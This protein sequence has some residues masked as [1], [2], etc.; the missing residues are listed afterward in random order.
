MTT[1]QINPAAPAPEAPLTTV[2]DG[3][4]KCDE[5]DQPAVFAYAFPW[6]GPGSSGKVCGLHASLKQQQA[7]NLS[8]EVVL[9][10]L[11]A[12]TNQPLTRSERVAL[13]AETYALEE[14]VKDLKLTGANLY[15]ENTR[16][17]QQLHAASAR[18]E[19][20]AQQL[21]QRDAE[22]RKLEDEHEQTL[23]AYGELSAEATRLRAL[24]KL[25]PD[26]TP[27]TLPSER[28]LEGHTV[29]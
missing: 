18:Q 10:A 6:T 5:C 17:T 16:L 24:V 11:P 25:L 19:A 27:E 20:T 14:E 8:R 22:L 13:K 9:S 7:A 1:P 4:P 23:T 2:A 28:G 12:P 26:P 29:G 21:A 3:P 15:N